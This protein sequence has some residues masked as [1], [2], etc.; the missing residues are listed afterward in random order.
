MTRLGLN[1]GEFYAIIFRFFKYGSLKSH[2]VTQE[3]IKIIKNKSK[4]YDSFL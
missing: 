1:L 2:F 3:I 4:S